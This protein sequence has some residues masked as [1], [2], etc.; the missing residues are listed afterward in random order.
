MYDYP[1]SLQFLGPNDQLKRCVVCTTERGLCAV[2]AHAGIVRCYLRR[3]YGLWACDIFNICHSAE[4]NK[5]V[6]ATAPVNP[7]DNPPAASV[8]KP[9]G[10]GDTDTLIAGQM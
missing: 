8:R 4:F 3:V 5:I 7:Y 10:M 6:E 2:R 1:K 9:H